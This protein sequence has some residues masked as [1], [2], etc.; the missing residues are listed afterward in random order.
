[1]SD[2]RIKDTVAK[3]SLYWLL[4]ALLLVMLP[5]AARVP[6]W[7][8]G[9]FLVLLGWR[10]LIAVRGWRIPPRWLRAVFTVAGV[11]VVYSSYGTLVGR[12]AGVALLLSMLA[13]KL[14]EM[15]THRDVYVTVLIAYFLVIT[16]FLYSQTILMAIYMCGVVVVITAALIDLNRF[17]H[18]GSALARQNLRFALSILLQAAPF[19]LVLFVLFPRIG[20]PLWGLPQDAFGST[21]GLSDEMSPGDI[22]QLI[23]SDN[24]AF[25]V[26]F[27]GPMP[28]AGDRYWRGPVLW[29]TDGRRWRAAAPNQRPAYEP[30]KVELKGAPLTYSVTLEPHKRR[31]LYALDLPVSTP[32]QALRTADF[33]LHANE[34]VKQRARYQVTSHTTY[35]M[36]NLSESERERGLQLPAVVNHRTREL[37]QRWREQYEPAGVVAQALRLFG[38]EDFTYTLTPPALGSADPID[39][40]LFSTRQGF[41]E[42]YSSAFVFLM[43][44][45]GIP[46]RIVT[47]Y[48]GGELNAIGDYLVVRQRD[49]HAW[50]EVWLEDVGWLRIDP[51]S[52]VAPERIM[53]SIQV[54]PGREGEAVQFE[55]PGGAGLR[56]LAERLRQGWDSIN[57]GWN[58]WV[59][60]YTQTQQ[61]QF[62]KGLGLGIESW[63]G[64]ITAL[65]VALVILIAAVAAVV[66]WRDYQPEDA[67]ARLWQRFCRKLARKGLARHPAE[68]PL[69]Y[70]QRII[71]QRP[72]LRG[73]VQRIAE[74]YIALRYAPA[75]SHIQNELQQLRR[76]VARFSP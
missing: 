57:N 31:W 20:A 53:R 34:E 68:G 26:K 72:E 45:A 69:D 58:Q 52:A 50:A 63:K 22:T 7:V 12:D 74:L 25:R 13:I 51:T 17:G 18:G 54:A 33:Q 27:D 43:R 49:A 62:L 42:H 48:Q 24:V 10:Y 75:S 29:H 39:Q 41:C 32:A 4:G 11:A 3:Q 8:T 14:L 35:T 30:P 47:G 64:M 23:L 61:E 76:A 40:F 55:L 66:L 70:A 71:S 65:A 19:M 59:L 67:V 15:V 9:F 21:S 46:A 6:P 44:A 56:A 36:A 28:P 5:H 37:A 16:H 73:S 2:P 60:N 38:T 1:M